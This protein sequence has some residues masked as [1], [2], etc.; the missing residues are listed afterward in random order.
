MASATGHSGA[1]PITPEEPMLTGKERESFALHVM[2]EVRRGVAA[3]TEQFPLY[4]WK[5]GAAAAR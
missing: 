4:A 1:R 2:E 5:L 3:L